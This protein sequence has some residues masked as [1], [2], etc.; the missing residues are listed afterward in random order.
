MSLDE[1]RLVNAFVGF[2]I[3]SGGDWPA[4]FARWSYEITGVE[5]EV[6]T[7]VDNAPRSPVPELISSSSSAQHC[8][9]LEVKTSSVDDRQAKSYSAITI[10]QLVVAGLAADEL[11]ISEAS[12]DVI[13]MTREETAQRLSDDFGRAGVQFPLISYNSSVFRLVEGS[14]SKN[15]MH[16]VFATGLGVVEHAWPMHFIRCDRDSTDGEIAALCVRAMVA[17]L[18]RYGEFEIEQLASSSIDFW[19]Q[20]GSSDKQHFRDRLTR[21]VVEAERT[22]FQAEISRD[23]QKRRWTKRGG[24]PGNP[25]HLDRISE[26]AE[27]FVRRLQ[28]GRP[29]KPDQPPLFPYGMED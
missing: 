10:N 14:I 20:R 21:L 16:N 6:D 2:C 4:P 18:L 28:E 23:G 24:R 19:H 17:L 26:L 15:E 8:A 3:P 27:T 13:Y 9:I 22:E 5:R 25:K 29:F 12:I 7:V 11:D 1:L